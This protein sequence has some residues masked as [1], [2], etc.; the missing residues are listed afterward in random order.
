MLAYLEF[1]IAIISI[2][3]ITKTKCPPLQVTNPEL[4]DLMIR[5]NDVA[6][7]HYGLKVEN[8]R[9]IYNPF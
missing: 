4:F 8:G 5:R 1:G 9:V 3:V 2:L 6:V 7:Q